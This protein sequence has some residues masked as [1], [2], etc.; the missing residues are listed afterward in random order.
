MRISDW[1]S[2]VCSSDLERALPLEHGSNF[3]DI[4]G[5]PAAGGKHVRWGMIFRSGG[6][7]LL[8]D[9]DEQ[10]IGALKLGE[11]VDLR[12][13]EERVLAPTRIYGVRYT[14]VG[15]SMGPM[16]ANLRSEEHTF[17]I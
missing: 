17:D 13:S 7:P 5:Y 9:A 6:T 3:R 12:S 4:G 11:M 16:S 8:N 10:R 15:Y 14:A 2:D 1:S